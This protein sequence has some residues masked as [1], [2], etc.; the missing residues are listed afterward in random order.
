MSGF[1]EVRFPLRLA[2]GATGGPVRRTDIVNL[3][4]GREQRNQRWRDSRRSYDAGSGVKSLTD[5]Y[6]VLEFFEARG[7]QLY[8]FRFRDPVDWKS[9]APGE[10]LS[11]TDQAIGTGDGETA[12]FQLVK[13]YA[14]GGGSWT[15]RIVKPVTGSVTLSVDGV[16]VP[17]EAWSVDAA[18]GIVTFTAGHAPP[19]G[20]AVRAG[21]EF[22][23]PVRFD[24]DRI[25]VNLAHF[26]AGRIPTIPLTEVL[27]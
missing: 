11:A 17:A 24:T 18:T 19:A 3:S 23:V 15:R 22:D 7:G 4:N 1:H 13:T 14:D 8:G 12:A 27:A 6:A 5:L 20:A 26:D 10:A 16:A 2:L 21:Y 9:C 25:D